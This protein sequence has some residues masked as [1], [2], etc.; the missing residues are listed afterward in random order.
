MGKHRLYAFSNAKGEGQIVIISDAPEATVRKQYETDC[1]DRT[2]DLAL[3]IV[4]DATR[5][6]PCDV[7][8]RY[9]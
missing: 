8:L 6:F 9:P 1:C 7:E 2:L 5:S 3:D 4:G